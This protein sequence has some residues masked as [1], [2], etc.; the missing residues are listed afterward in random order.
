ML[1]WLVLLQLADPQTRARRPAP[2]SPAFFTSTLPP[3]EL[4]NKQA[5]LDTTDGIIVLDLLGE[6]APNHVAHIILRA[7]EGA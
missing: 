5:V 1:P 2:P 7:R 3:S 6:A 4:S